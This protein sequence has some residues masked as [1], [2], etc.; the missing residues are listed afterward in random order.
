MQLCLEH[1]AQVLNIGPMS[2]QTVTL[3]LS[4]CFIRYKMASAN[5]E[6]QD[7]VKLFGLRIQDVLSE[8]KA[9]SWDRSS[10]LFAPDEPHFGGNVYL[11]NKLSI[12]K[13]ASPAS[14]LLHFLFPAWHQGLLILPTSFELDSS[15]ASAGAARWGTGNPMDV[16]RGCKPVSNPLAVAVIHSEV[17]AS[18]M[19][20]PHYHGEAVIEFPF[21]ELHP[22]KCLYLPLEVIRGI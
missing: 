12:A 21:L 7:G 11:S 16:V 8:S 3:H 22:L 9:W 4:F 6:R 17:V 19:I 2:L 18:S 14:L 1:A 10:S 20:M 13:E 5:S 15:L